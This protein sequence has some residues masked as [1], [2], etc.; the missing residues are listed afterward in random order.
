MLKLLVAIALTVFTTIAFC[1]DTPAK[2]EGFTYVRTV[3]G[4]AEY[5][6]DANGLQVLLLT[7]KSAPVATFMVTYHVGSRNEV[8]GTT[9]ATH[10]LEHLMFKGSAKHDRSLGTGYDQ[11]IE[12][13]GAESNATTWLDRTNYFATVPAN[14][15]PLL[16]EVEAD[17]M[18]NLAL[19]EDDRRP[20][21]TVVRNEFERGENKPMGALSK[22]LWAAAFQAH[23]YHHD[24]IG[25]RSDIERVPIEKLR[26]FYDTYYWPDNATATVIGDFDPAQALAAIKQHYGAIPKSPHPFPQVYTEEPE[27]SGQ[28]RVL[29]KRSGEIGIVALAHKIP[30]ATHADWPAIE[31]FSSILSYGKTSRCYRALTDK[32]L[33]LDVSGEASFTRDPSLHITS[34]YLNNGVKHEEVERKLMAEIEKIKASGVTATE[35]QIAVSGM[36][37]HRAFA[38]DGSYSLANE[39]NDCIAVGDW[40]LY[41]SLEDKFKAVTPADVQRVA[42]KYFIDDH[43]TV[44][45]FVPVQTKS[46]DKPKSATAKEETF[47]PK[48][49]LA[50]KPL[51]TPLGDIPS[52]ALAHR[53]T[54]EQIRGM[55]VL[56][57]PSAAKDIVHLVLSVPA[58]EAASSNRALAHVVA[59]MLERGT[60]KHDQFAFADLLEKVGAT[61]ESKVK[62]DTV[63]FS[64]KCLSKDM[65]L[66]ISLLA[67]Q[68]ITP[69]FLP[70]E[71]LK[72][73][74]E[75]ADGFQQSLES[76]DTQAAIAFSRAIFPKGH[77]SRQNNV[78]EMLADLEKVKL[79]DVRNFYTK[80]YGPRDSH[81]V[82]VGDLD[83]AAIETEISKSF[84]PWN[85]QNLDQNDFMYV[86]NKAYEAY[87]GGEVVIPMP[88][89]ASVSIMIGQQSGVNAHDPDWLALNVG[90]KILGEGFISRL[91]GNV[92]DREGLTYGI[93]AQMKDD[94]YR[95][96]TWS[97]HGTFAP[98]LLE[99]GLAS[100]RRELESWWKEGITAD[101]LDYRKSSMIGSFTVSL[102]TTEGLAERLL[103]S[104]ERG[105]DVKWLDEYPAKINALTLDEV[106]AAIK[107]HLDPA[108]MATVKAG[109][110]K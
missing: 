79:A 10:L 90:T 17:R 25:W 46:D 16:I 75:M 64:V 99:K 53:V 100:T 85:F 67:E 3:G 87:K 32:N 84:E 56:I 55:D 72:L 45:W 7:V 102:E 47:K 107:K 23:P 14:A 42:K 60:K 13:V 65:P 63:E 31:V 82:A 26:A 80:N 12:R 59:G 44:G 103:L 20:E 21:M 108:K 4:I 92:R 19:R 104:V 36:M 35:V 110:V 2:V 83:V 106:N 97:I 81:L 58:G 49:V 93:A 76:T 96:G 43:S 70:E 66:V 5:K 51:T 86:E 22:E 89:K 98:A 57:C 101:E 6:L 30:E 48:V 69:A 50:P 38:R 88:G 11:I 109:T 34:A 8:T 37:S 33:T 54:R 91:I 105:F 52:A 71:L 18:R 15:L 77:P 74:K 29:L 94:T 39:I 40:T 62:I 61:I 41:V 68:L 28:R 27:Q 78:P 9:G 73:K 95:N 1:D 24:T